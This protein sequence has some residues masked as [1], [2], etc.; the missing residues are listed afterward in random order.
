MLVGS[1]HKEKALGDDLSPRAPLYG[2][3]QS[4]VKIWVGFQVGEWI[5]LPPPVDTKRGVGI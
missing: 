1:R 4:V 5:C 2:T 3:R